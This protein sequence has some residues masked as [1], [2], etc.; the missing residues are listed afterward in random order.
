MTA[1]IR[2]LS[3]AVLAGATAN[4][5]AASSKRNSRPR[6]AGSVYGR[7]RA[8][9]AGAPFRAVRARDIRARLARQGIRLTHEAVSQ[10]LHKMQRRRQVQRVEIPGEWFSRW[11]FAQ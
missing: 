10:K 3:L 5:A 9:L 1:S 4:Q 11:Q 7:I 8:V 6:E 2:P